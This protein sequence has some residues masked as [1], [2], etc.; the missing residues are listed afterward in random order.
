MARPTSSHIRT[1][2]TSLISPQLIC[3]RAKRARV[4][5]RRRKIDPV[6]LVYTLILSFDRG[7]TRSMAGLRRAY[8][9]A[10]G[11]SLV[12]S[13]FYDRFTPALAELLRQLVEHA[14]DKLSR[15]GSKLH[16]TLS[17]FCKVFIADGSL[18]RL[19][20]A[21]QAYFPSVW[22]NHTKASAKLHLTIDAASRGPAIVQIVPG[23]RHD[24]SV[25][26]PGPWC[27]GALFVFDL[28]YYDGKL[29]QRI[30][31]HGGHFLCR[32][33]KDANFLIRDANVPDW[34]GRRRPELAAASRGRSFD[35]RIEHVYRDPANRDWTKRRM[36]LRL[37][38]L[39]QPQT[40][41]HHLTSP[42]LPRS[43]SVQRPSQPF[44]RYAG[45]SS[46]SSASSSISSASKTCPA[47][48]SP[49]FGAYS[50][51]RCSLW[52]SLAAS[53]MHFVDELR[54]L[55]QFRPTAA[56]ASSAHSH[57]FFF[58]Y[59]SL[60]RICALVSTAPFGSLSVAKRQT[61]TGDGFSF[62]NALPLAS[63]FI[64]NFAINR[65]PMIRPYPT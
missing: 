26:Q 51:R 58:S 19:G 4:V 17:N 38:G 23:S 45:K 54:R 7:V 42:A 47:E 49:R 10:T 59:S 16:G 29:F 48:I 5:R 20:D 12:A 18:V 39:W 55:L 34:D 2:L 24:V 56:P 32:V 35:V 15:S 31:E 63:S 3:R 36:S 46:S 14:F 57:P 8:I 65:S 21:L 6:A 52:R 27:H 1:T 60:R 30:L 41:R 43:C 50:T 9:S 40:Q 13:A 61:P 25:L 64:E 44:T 33:K 62:A 37:V 22:S 11:T 28:A 53:P